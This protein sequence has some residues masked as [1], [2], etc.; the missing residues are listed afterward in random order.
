MHRMKRCKRNNPMP[1][2][3]LC[4]VLRAE[5]GE[6]PALVRQRRFSDR[7]LALTVYTYVLA[8]AAVVVSLAYGLVTS[9]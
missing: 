5:R 3:V 9:T 2:R 1:A 4:A 8:F 7:G 6:S